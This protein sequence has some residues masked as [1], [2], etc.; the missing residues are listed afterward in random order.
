MLAISESTSGPW[1]E[2]GNQ[3]EVK[4]LLIK[5]IKDTGVLMSKTETVHIERGILYYQPDK[6][7]PPS[8]SVSVSARV[9]TIHIK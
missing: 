7:K 8:A 9:F 4:R 5:T 6:H 3:A 2:A 1:R